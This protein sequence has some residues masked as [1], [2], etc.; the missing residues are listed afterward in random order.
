MMMLDMLI[1][2][3]S[4]LVALDER[5]RHNA[6]HDNCPMGSINL[7][8]SLSAIARAKRGQQGEATKPAYR[9]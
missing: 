1:M 8:G 5:E 4:T 9:V 6:R 3:M 7:Y 2:M